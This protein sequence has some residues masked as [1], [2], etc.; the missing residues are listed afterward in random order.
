ML[1]T[2]YFPFNMFKNTSVIEEACD[3]YKLSN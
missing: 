1:L 2:T 3:V